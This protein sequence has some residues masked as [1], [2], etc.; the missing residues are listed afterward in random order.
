MDFGVLVGFCSRSPLFFLFLFFLLCLFLLRLF[1]LRLLLAPNKIHQYFALR[2]I[3]HRHLPVLSKVYVEWFDCFASFALLRSLL[4]VRLV[5]HQSLFH[6][7]FFDFKRDF[8]PLLFHSLLH[9]REGQTL[10]RNMTCAIPHTP[11]NAGTSFAKHF[12]PNFLLER[13]VSKSPLLLFLLASNTQ[14]AW[15]PSRCKL[16]DELGRLFEILPF[17][18]ASSTCLSL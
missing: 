7:V 17:A 4:K 14:P 10:R 18:P 12:Y 8:S 1:F 15:Q 9:L 2:K 16:D 13:G 3:N 5:C 6:S 11:R